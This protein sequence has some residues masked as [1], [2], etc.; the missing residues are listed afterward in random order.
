[1]DIKAKAI[2]K[3]LGVILFFFCLTAVYFAPA[4]FEDK[5]IQ[6]TDVVKY[7]GMAKEAKDYVKTPESKEH[8]VVGWLGNAFSGMPSYSVTNVKTPTNFLSYIERIPRT[9]GTE[10]GMILCALISCYILMCVLGVNSWL[11]IAGAIAFTFASYNIIIL[12]AGHITKAYVIACMPLTIAGM[13]LVFKQKYLWGSVLTMLGIALSL[14]N[15]HVQVTYYLT[16]FC[17]FLFLG[18]LVSQIKER[19]FSQLTKATSILIV[20]LLIAVLQSAG[21]LYANYELSKESIRGKSELTAATTGDTGKA[22]GGLDFDYAFAWSYGKAETMT[23]LIPNFYGGES[24]GTLD[25]DSEV[26]KAMVANR[27]QVGKEVQSATYWGDQPF[28]SGPVYFGA[29]VCFLFLLGMFVIRNQ[30]KWWMLAASIFCIF[31]SWGKNFMWFNELMFHYLPMYNKFRAP[32]MSLII[33]GFAFVIIAVWGLSDILSGK[34][35]TKK[36]KKHFYLSLGITGGLCLL[37]WLIP[38]AFLNFQSANDAQY[39]FPSWYYA[40]LLADR[41]SL[42]QA[43]AFRSLV[44][45]LLAAGLLYWFIAAEKKTKNRAAILSLGIASLLLIDL[46]TVDK[47]YLNNDTFVSQQQSQPFTQSVADKA[48]LQDQDPSY[49][50]LNLNNPFNES[51]TSYYHKSIGGYSAAKLGRYQELIDHRISNEMKTLIEALQRSTTI[52]DMYDALQKTPTLNMLNTRYILY[53]PEQAPIR[54]PYAFGNAWFVEDVRMVENA[55]AEIQ[56]LNTINPLLTAVVDKRFEQDIHTPTVTADSLAYIELLSYEPV[57]MKYRSTTQTE[58]LAV[59]SEV[60]YAHGWES[61]IDGKPAPH[62]RTDWILRGMYIP[63]G[64]HEIE[65]VFRPQTYITAHTIA[66]YSSL[67]ILVYIFVAM[68]YG[69]FTYFKKQETT[70]KNNQC[71]I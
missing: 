31:L 29:A 68:G 43:D 20:C 62:F 65:F 41:K 47:R 28:T 8:K 54:N 36:L 56:A 27:M 32:S 53:N 71:T 63:A 42:L 45:I 35:E 69:L 9:L 17:L 57:K 58:Q 50:V 37:F 24:N 48:I 21:S 2:V 51:Y 4:V 39:Q 1:M 3:H 61:Y 6:Q 34:A 25:S 67:L 16:I 13:F 22:S 14:R 7:E 10:A 18:Y 55:D 12:E 46:W 40:A 70:E 44:Y 38:G 5:V 64:E 23:L 49:R 33:P 30:L 52:T 26:Y 60:Y 15:N 66:S 19:N 11:A 59:F